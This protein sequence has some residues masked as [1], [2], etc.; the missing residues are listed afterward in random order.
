MSQRV[1][2]RTLTLALGAAVAGLSGAGGLGDCR[3]AERTR[4][5]TYDDDYDLFRGTG[6]SPEDLRP[7]TL[8]ELRRSYRVEEDG[9]VWRVYDRRTGE[10][11]YIYDAPPGPVTLLRP[12]TA[13][14]GRT[15]CPSPSPSTS[16]ARRT[17]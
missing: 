15:P 4:S 11:L 14:G 8:E 7:L 17:C 6:D 9:G 3:E 1:L 2:A 5:A 12:T 13:P 16:A 10:R